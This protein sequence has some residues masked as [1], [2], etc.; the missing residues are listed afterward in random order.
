MAE[1]RVEIAYIGDL[2][3]F[4]C[5]NTVGIWLLGVFSAFRLAFFT[6]D[7][8]RWDA[9]VHPETHPRP[10]PTHMRRERERARLCVNRKETNQNKGF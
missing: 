3:E 6:S 2:A 7:K 9:S 8:H 1:S 10:A 5:S 4:H